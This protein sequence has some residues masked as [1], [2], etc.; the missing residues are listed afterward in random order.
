GE[1]IGGAP[2]WS[3]NSRQIAFAAINASGVYV[4]NADGSNRVMLS[5]TDQYS[6]QVAWAPD[7]RRVA[8]S[9]VMGA[10]GVPGSDIYVVNADGTHRLKLT[11][12]DTAEYRSLAWSPNSRQ[13]AFISR[14]NGEGIINLINA[15]GTNLHQLTTSMPMPDIEDESR[16]LAWSSQ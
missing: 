7:G 10:F 12:S 1:D 8:F 15:D 11:H 5:K 3:P 2:A 4:M 13:I 9:A 14:A 16:S 6:D